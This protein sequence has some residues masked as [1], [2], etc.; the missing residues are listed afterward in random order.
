MPHVAEHRSAMQ[1]LDLTHSH[2]GGRGRALTHISSLSEGKIDHFP[3]CLDSLSARAISSSWRLR[4]LDDHNVGAFGVKQFNTCRRLNISTQNSYGRWERERERPGKRWHRLVSM[5]DDDR[6]RCRSNW[7]IK[8]AW[9]S[10]LSL[11]H[12]PAHTYTPKHIHIFPRRSFLVLNSTARRPP[13]MANGPGVLPSITGPLTFYGFG[14]GARIR[15]TRW[16]RI[17]PTPLPLKGDTWGAKERFE[18]TLWS[19]WDDHYQH[20]Q[21]DIYF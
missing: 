5:D 15:H 19:S 2:F 13:L 6:R 16:N 4:P 11:T 3:S 7:I 1:W 21:S 17:F 9:P 20:N 10:T 18:T 14:F 8:E 12:A